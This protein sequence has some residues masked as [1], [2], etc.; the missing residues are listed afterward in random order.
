MR[1]ERLPIPYV[2]GFTAAVVALLFSFVIFAGGSAPAAPAV[3]E[4]L[5]PLAGVPQDGTTL[6]RPDAPATLIAYTDLAALDARLDNALPALLD[7]WVDRGALKIELRAMG[8]QHAMNLVEDP[9]AAAK[10][11]YA[12]GQQDALWSWFRAFNAK[13][14]GFLDAG[15]VRAIGREL[16]GVDPRRLSLEARSDEVAALVAADQKAARRA[17]LDD[18]FALELVAGGGA[19]QRL[20]LG[21]AR[22]IVDGVA[23]ALDAAPTGRLTATPAAG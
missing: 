9:A 22:Q 7:R 3:R 8:S 4:A 2:A 19:P 10:L 17:Q 20:R 5:A 16:P 18:V 13:N 6:G 21:S 23:R 14:V 12:A 1:L 11:M 15:D